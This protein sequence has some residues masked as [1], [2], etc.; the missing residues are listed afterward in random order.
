MTMLLATEWAQRRREVLERDDHVCIYCGLEARS[1]DHV[2]PI[3]QGG[4]DDA[5]NLVASCRSCNAEKNGRTPDQWKNGVTTRSVSKCKE[6]RFNRYV[7]I[8]IKRRT[9]TRFKAARDKQGEGMPNDRCTSDLFLSFLLCAWETMT[10]ERRKQV[11]ELVEQQCRTGKIKRPHMRDD[12]L[13]WHRKEQ[14]QC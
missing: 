7:Q 12:D 8:A 6:K 4:T 3:C 2:I 9:M 11:N 14:K 5:E 10:D 13:R 1:I